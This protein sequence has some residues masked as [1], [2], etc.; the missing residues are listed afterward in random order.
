M[1]V[2]LAFLYEANEGFAGK[3]LPG[4]FCLTSLIGG[5]S[6]ADD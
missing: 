5:R 4:G 1:H 3:L 2:G 6:S